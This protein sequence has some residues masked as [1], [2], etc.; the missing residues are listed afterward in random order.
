MTQAIAVATAVGNGPAFSA[1]AS[2]NTTLTNATFVK[3]NFQTKEFDTNTNYSTSTSRFTPTVAGY[4]I[5]QTGIGF[6]GSATSESEIGLYKNGSVVRYGMDII[7]AGGSL[8]YNIQG[9]WLVYANGSTDYFEIYLYQNSSRDAVA[10]QFV[11]YFTGVL[12]R[13]A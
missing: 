7:T 4:Y 12:V 10:A 2:S 1:Y 6:T 11:T 8:L 13:S 3:V 5:L 9:N